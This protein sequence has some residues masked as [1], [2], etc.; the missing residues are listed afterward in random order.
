[1]PALEREGVSIAGGSS[2]AAIGELSSSHTGV[3]GPSSV[4]IDRTYTTK[5]LGFEMD[6]EYF[7]GAEDR[8]RLHKVSFPSLTTG[9]CRV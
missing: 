9:G 7:K 3:T 6:V 4:Q 5:Y 1:M 8:I 2:N